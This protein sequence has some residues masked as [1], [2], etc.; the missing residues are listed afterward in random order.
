[1]LTFDY[2]PSDRRAVVSWSESDAGESWVRIIRDILVQSCVEGQAE[3]GFA[4]STPW[5]RFLAMRPSILEVISAHGLQANRDFQITPTT[6]HLLTQ[7]RQRAMGYGNALQ[8]E[9]LE[10]SDV[11]QRL[12]EAG[13]A[14][15]LTEPQLR[16][17]CLLASLPAAA[18][19]SVP[20]A[21]KT[22]EA[23]AT[24]VCRSQVNDRLLVICP[25]NAFGAW[26]EQL[27]ECFPGTAERFVRL[28]NQDRIPGQLADD[29]RFMVIGYQQFARVREMVAEHLVDR[30]VHVFIDES[31]RIKGHSN[32]S[33]EAVL[34]MSHLPVSKL[35]MSGTP[36]PQAISDLVP[37]FRFLFPEVSV[38]ESA[39]VD[40]V[41]PVYVRTTKSELGLPQPVRLVRRLAMDPLQSRVYQ[42]M[43]SEVA[44][45]AAA[46]LSRHDRNAFR[47]LGRSVM[48]VLQF[49]SHPALLANDVASAYSAELAAALAEGR[50]PKVRYVLSRARRLAK[51]GKKVVI[52]T[53]FVRNV[54]YLAESLQDLGAVFIHGGVDAGDDADEDTR[55]GKL[56]R[57]HE[58]DV[59]VLV[60]NPAAAAEGISLHTVCHHAI[61]LDRS[62][63]AAHYL[64]SVDRIHRLGLAEGQDTTIE[65]V[66]CEGTIDETVSARLDFKI[67]QMA[68]V[69]DDPGLCVTPIPVEEDEEGTEDDI[70]ASGLDE[71]DVRALLASLGGE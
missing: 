3:G 57:F 24:F 21:G 44:R 59:M 28:R 35:V 22:T 39:V 30:R 4:A 16:N 58:P 13:F 20:G 49:V 31:H 6:A 46:A 15:P 54:E 43:K 29:P 2:R 56:K 19:F 27:S 23:L 62:F 65:L 69:L 66:E 68:T 8:S 55:E 5:W 25:K 48:R 18:T 51:E 41:R 38:D 40:A 17:I 11:L 10:P 37:Q 60:A 50:G 12:S 61:Y 70:N 45:S 7:A 34:S 42:L 47:T 53:S 63:N 64:Q 32:V 67:A 71:A 14:R 26:D 33:T 9:I 1:M 52:W 36:M